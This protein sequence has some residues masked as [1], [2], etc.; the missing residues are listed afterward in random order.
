M[1]AAITTASTTLEGQALEIAVAMQA[2]ELSVAAE[3]RP[4]NVE[5]DFSTEDEQVAITMNLPIV[6]SVVSGAPKFTAETYL[7]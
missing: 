5:V 6:L 1:A 7:A 3:T 4:N 2:A